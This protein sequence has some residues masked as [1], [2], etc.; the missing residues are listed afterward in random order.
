MRGTLPIITCDSEY[1]CDVWVT[2]MYE[3]GV[4]NWREV[5]RGWAYDPH[6]DRDTALCP[7]HKEE[8]P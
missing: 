8:A 3:L 6:K 4:T 5:M 2:D 1:G 7:E